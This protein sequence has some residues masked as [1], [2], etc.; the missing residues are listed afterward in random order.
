MYTFFNHIRDQFKKSQDSLVQL[1][2]IHILSFLLLFIFNT[3]CYISGY[4]KIIPLVYEKLTLPSLYPLLLRSPWTIITYS[5]V[6]KSILDLFWDAIMLYY[7]GQSIRS[8]S[9]TKHILRLYFLG[10]IVGAFVF[11]ILYQLAPPFKG[12]SSNLIGP[13]AA[14][15]AMMAA[16]CV[17]MPGIRVN[18]YFTS[19]QLKYIVMFLLLLALMH[20]QSNQAGYYLTQLSGSLA[21]Y[22]YA[23]RNKNNGNNNWSFIY[24]K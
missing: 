5:F 18:F 6:H 3:A 23:K 24:N 11:C 1:I 4:E 22:I 17:F 7:C 19:I 14:I 15:Y 20:L 13:S 21:G 8:V 12:I 16:I 9:R 10:Q 2:W